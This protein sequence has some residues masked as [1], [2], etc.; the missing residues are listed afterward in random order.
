MNKQI[1]QQIAEQT[2]EFLMNLV[3]DLIGHD[4]HCKVKVHAIR[5]SGDMMRFRVE[6]QEVNVR[7]DGVEMTPEAKDFVDLASRGDVTQLG[8]AGIKPEDLGRVFTVNGGRQFKVLGWNRK[9][10]KRPVITKCIDN[11]VEFVWTVNSV[12]R[13]LGDKNV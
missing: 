10:R 11:G 8:Q 4:G 5:H 7:E 13:Y 9:A 3:D 1:S 12:A 6:V 2:S